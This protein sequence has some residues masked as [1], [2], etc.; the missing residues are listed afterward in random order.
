VNIESYS[1][2]NKEVKME[3]G[4]A[5]IMWLGIAIGCAF[6]CAVFIAILVGLIIAVIRT[7]KEEKD[8]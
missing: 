8:K 7:I 6:L 5:L 2:I 4:L 1:R 3:T